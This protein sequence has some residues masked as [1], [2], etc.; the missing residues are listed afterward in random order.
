VG[1]S[2]PRQAS[3]EYPVYGGFYNTSSYLLD[4]VM[5]SE[6]GMS[7]SSRKLYNKTSISDPDSTIR[8]YLAL[9]RR[10]NRFQGIDSAGLCTMAGRYGK[11]LLVPS[12]HKLF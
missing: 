9:L 5:L 11:P 4:G 10:Y 12:P 1:V 3:P 8:V 2:P 7:V 6:R